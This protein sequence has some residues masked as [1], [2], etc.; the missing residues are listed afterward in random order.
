ML[1]NTYSAFDKK[2]V[3]YLGTFNARNDAEASRI[4]GD[5]AKN[6]ENIVGVHPED[7]ALY[8]LGSFDDSNGQIVG[9]VTP[10]F[11]AEAVSF[12][13]PIPVQEAP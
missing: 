13:L 7:F 6:L 4:F 9:E 12:V 5:A 1:Q 3:Y 8:R 2:A 11:V 10:V